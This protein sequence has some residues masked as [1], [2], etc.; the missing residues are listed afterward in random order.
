MDELK[1][2]RDIQ[3]LA[4]R[5]WFDFSK[6]EIVLLPQYIQNKNKSQNIN[7]DSIVT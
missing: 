2:K 3:K 5:I 7:I 4:I 1:N 6:G